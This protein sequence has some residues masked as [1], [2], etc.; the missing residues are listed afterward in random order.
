M[1]LSVQYFQHKVVAL[2]YHLQFAALL[3]YLPWSRCRVKR[4]EPFCDRN[5]PPRPAQLEEF[6]AFYA[7]EQMQMTLQLRIKTNMKRRCKRTMFYLLFIK[8]AC[9]SGWRCARCPVLTVHEALAEIYLCEQTQTVGTYWIPPMKV[10]DEPSTGFISSRRRWV[11]GLCLL[12]R[13]SPRVLSRSLLHS[14]CQ[15]V[16]GRPGADWSVG[17]TP[18]PRNCSLWWQVGLQY[19]G[20]HEGTTGPVFIIKWTIPSLSWHMFLISLSD[21]DNLHQTIYNQMQYKKTHL[22]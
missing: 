7:F 13:G 5:F 4:Y 12:C 20:H 11:F 19:K 15:A 2:Q 14:R 10:S 22:S 8:Q 1:E 3:L 6:P 9:Y 17:W 18:S 16:K 21:Q